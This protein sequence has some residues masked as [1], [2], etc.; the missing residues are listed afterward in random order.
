MSQPPPGCG[1]GGGGKTDTTV[2]V[3]TEPER[4]RN[5]PE[6]LWQ[7]NTTHLSL[8]LGQRRLFL[9][10]SAL[11]VLSLSGPFLVP[12]QL[13]SPRLSILSSN[14]TLLAVP[15]RS[16]LPESL[17]TFCDICRRDSVRSEELMFRKCA[18]LLWW[19]VQSPLLPETEHPLVCR[20]SRH[21]ASAAASWAAGDHYPSLCSLHLTLPPKY[22]LFLIFINNPSLTLDQPRCLL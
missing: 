17:P 6:R 12:K 22:T 21:H 11:I 8:L 5:V 7:M 9:L 13:A 3:V 15:E 18:A 19:K 2:P 20:E 10:N 1:G 4:L 16:L 14:P